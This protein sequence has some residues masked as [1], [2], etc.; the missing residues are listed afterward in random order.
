[1]TGLEGDIYSNSLG[2]QLTKIE[3]GEFYMGFEGNTLPDAL[4]GRET[5]RQKVFLIVCLRKLNGNTL[6]VLVPGHLSTLETH[7][8]NRY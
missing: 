5:H 1:M 3:A 6:V 2:M 8:R 7:C 4:V